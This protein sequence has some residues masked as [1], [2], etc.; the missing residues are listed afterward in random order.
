MVDGK[1]SIVRSNSRIDGVQRCLGLVHDEIKT[2]IKRKVL[3]KP[4]FVSVY[5]PLCA[6]HVDAV[7]ALINYLISNFNISEVIIAEA[8]ALGEFFKGIENYGYTRLKNKYGNLE[9]I[10]LNADELEYVEVYDRHG[11]PFKIRVTKTLLREDLFKVSTCRPKTHDTVVVTLTIKNMAVGAPVKEDKPKIHQNYFFINLN[12]A[13]LA[14]PTMPDLGVVDGLEGMEGTGPVSGTSRP[15]GSFFAS[16][17]LSANPVHIDSIVAY[18]M[19]FNP[20][21]IGYLYILSKWGYGEL[22]PRKIKT[23]SLSIEQVKVKFKPHP[24]YKIQLSWKAY[25][26]KYIDLIQQLSK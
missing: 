17:N 25:L 5:N 9:F 8:P 11:R 13:L 19:G 6:T 12:I 22:D 21:N 1:V 3:I 7:D 24:D 20:Y 10:D 26:T 4:N 18:C 23:I 15:W 2:R 14:R 16:V